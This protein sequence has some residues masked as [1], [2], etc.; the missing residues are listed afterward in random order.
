MSADTDVFV[1]DHFRV[2]ASRDEMAALFK[3]TVHNVVVEISSYCNRQCSYCPVSQVD[4]LSENRLLPEDVFDRLTSD[5]ASIDYDSGVCLNLYNEPTSDRELLLNRITTL[6]TALP[7]ARIYFSTNGDYLNRD[8]LKAMVD[9]GLSELYV[10]LHPPKGQPYDDAYSIGRFTEFAARMDRPLKIT[11]ALPNQ[12]IQGTMSLFG[13]NLYVFS[14]NYD[15]FGSD[16]AG[17]IESLREKAPVRTAPCARPFNDFTISYEGSL[18]PCC[19]MFVDNAH[20]KA[21]YSVGNIAAYP[22]I[23]HAYSSPAMVGWRK[24]MLRFGPKL[25]PCDTCS[26][27]NRP[28]TAE[29]HAVRDQIYEKFVGPIPAEKAPETLPAKISRPRHR[30]GLLDFLRR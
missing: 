30:I 21:K 25:T 27:D 22:S 11:A 6:R 20:H 1:E 29:E 15:I 18:F 19:Q 9:A 16:R 3:R 14:T 8:Y 28:G 5:L 2:P 13:I 17:A 26:E 7:R 23:F 24:S 4:R 12:S 10:T